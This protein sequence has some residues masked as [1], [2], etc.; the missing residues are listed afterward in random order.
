MS[1]N[2]NTP[3][4]QVEEKEL[5][6]IRRNWLRFVKL[7][8]WWIP[9]RCLARRMS[10]PDIRL[11]WRE[12]VALVMII[13]LTSGVMIFFIMVFG[14]LLCPRQYVM[15]MAELQTR[16]A[17]SEK[18]PPM[19]AIYGNLIDISSLSKR[20]YQVEKAFTA[21]SFVE[22]FGGADVTHYFA[23][24]LADCAQ[25]DEDKEFLHQLDIRRAVQIY[26]TT[27]SDRVSPYPGKHEDIDGILKKLYSKENGFYG[28]LVW[29]LS[30]LKSAT[31][32]DEPSGWY[33]MYKDE[34]FDLSD[35]RNPRSNIPKETWEK[36]FPGW[37]QKYFDGRDQLDWTKE[38]DALSSSQ[39]KQVLTCLKHRF[40]VG[41]LDTRNSV[42][43]KVS[44][45]TLLT[46]T[47]LM[48][49][50]IVVKFLAALQLGHRKRPEQ[51]DKFVMVQIPCYT[52]GE[53]SLRRTIDSVSVTD[54]DDKRKLLFII[55]DG[56]IIG[57][58][59]DRP[60]PR[61]VL[62]IL[63]VDPNLDPEPVAYKALGEGGKQLNMAKVYSGL[64]EVDGHVVPYL[65]VIKCGKPTERARPG[66]RGKRDSQLILMQFLCRALY[67]EPMCALELEIY[68][69]M[70]N[71][72]GVDP[73]FYEY[74][75][76]VDADTE[77]VSDSI[78]RLVAACVRDTRIM[79][80]CGETM[81]A[82]AD[83]SWVTM[84]QVYE[85]YISHHLS[86]AFESL[87]GA[88][89]CLPGCFCMY[90]IKTHQNQK[91][92]IV[93]HPV[94]Q[95]YSE[96]EV[97]TLHKKN[98]LSLG[99]DRYL[100]TLML[101]HFPQLKMKFT[102]DAKCKT[103]A[104]ERWSVL[105]SQRRRWINSTV[106]NLFE[107]LFLDQLCGF[108]LFSMRFVVFIDLFATLVQPAT[109]VY[110]AYLLVVAG[111][112]EEDSDAPSATISLIMLAVVYGL[113]AIIFLL[114][115][116][117]EHIGWMILYILG[118][119]LF[120]FC[121]PLYSFWH[122]DDFSWG[123]TRVVVGEG[124]KQKVFHGEGDTYD[125]ADVPL[126]KWSHHAHPPATL[127]ANSEAAPEFDACSDVSSLYMPSLPS[128]VADYRRMSFGQMSTQSSPTATSFSLPFPPVTPISH[129]QH[130]LASFP[131][132][133]DIAANVRA[134]LASN[135]L[136]KITKKR[137]RRTLA[138]LYGTDMSHKREFINACIEQ[139]L[140][141]E[142]GLS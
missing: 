136:S 33:I 112:A 38:I 85:Y 86:K 9:E 89:T 29:D 114:K 141:E 24:P 62:D 94:I 70:K 102:S 1:Q 104:P 83:D 140:A 116:R 142:H 63:G 44:Q 125:P 119:P 13:L 78:T 31:Q 47:G 6:R 19:V 18:Y 82:N 48:A 20:H 68:H 60:T 57:G 39:K 123:N 103:S 137:I 129:P 42:K 87:F 101:K 108:C 131:S 121:I 32:G 59:N 26:N 37:G 58:G 17:P 16:N 27:I 41:Q 107:L 54:Y 105:L 3:A 109:V 11:A 67:D 98:L 92:L 75:L 40:R 106:H 130:P 65:V 90:R 122:F 124:G 69:Q 88:V 25:S 93:S 76:M 5:S 51:Y 66:N 80:I 30:Y 43:C 73:E 133:Q 111:M 55:A 12:K 36:L 53:E 113:Q 7:T 71:V 139:Y 10:R 81:L 4:D 135:D 21:A 46:L 35:L 34:V 23:Y 56:M 28:T 79:G 134:I 96:N 132:D 50:V 8:T 126:V 64:Y 22:T 120:S 115:R 117:W 77:L 72:I 91:P 45:I 100:T 95:D 52:E 118:I 74:I 14:R 49:A 127:Y 138:K 128:P 2:P 97:D 99:E 110:L 61:I 84:I 15:N